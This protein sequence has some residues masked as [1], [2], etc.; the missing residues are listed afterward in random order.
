MRNKRKND[1][2]AVINANAQLGIPAKKDF[3]P[4][5]FIT[6]II[7]ISFDWVLG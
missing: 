2:N 1:K 4:L 7:L 3:F 5:V 6:Q